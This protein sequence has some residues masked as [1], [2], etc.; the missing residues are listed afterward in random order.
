MVHIFLPKM[1]YKGKTIFIHFWSRRHAVLLISVQG[2]VK[3]DDYVQLTIMNIIN[4][5]AVLGS[6]VNSAIECCCFCY[7]ADYYYNRIPNFEMIG[8]LKVWLFFL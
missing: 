1:I 6:W 5:V 7:D 8:T 3:L 4:V 2:I